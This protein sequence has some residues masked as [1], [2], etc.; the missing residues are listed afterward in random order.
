MA[1]K[2]N[3]ATQ[4]A[5]I[6][7]DQVA[8]AAKVSPA[9]VSRVLNGTAKVS[10]DKEKAVRKAVAKY[11]FTPNATARRLAGGRSGLIA[12]LMEESSEE[13]FL[14]PFW[15]Q[16]VQGF[17]TAITEAGLHPMLLIRPKSGTEDS[18]FSTLQ[19]GQMDGLAIF[20]WH[21]PLRSFE[22]MLDPKMAVVF[23]GDLGGSKKYPY[24]DVDNVKGGYLATKHLIDSECKNIVTITG[25]LKLQ[26]GRDRLDGYEKALTSAGI[27]IN[28]QLIIHG[29]YTQSKAEEL[30]RQF[31]KRKIKFDGVFAGNDLSALGAI[32]VLLQNGI[33]VPGKVKVVGF[34][35]SPIASRN[36]PSITTIR[37]PI[38]ELGA[39]VAHS[40][41][42]ILDGEEVE[43]KV[44]DVRLIKRQSSGAK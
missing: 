24:V 27:K 10:A 15:G 16:V 1:K 14:N 40:L 28:D 38:R 9:T 18:L 31:L 30:I 21:R 6:T 39:Q 34:D 12:L 33:T 25:D 43:D 3:V 22:K 35:D 29:D 37:Q 41:L 17:S 7:I 11:N 26:S 4:Q 19:A 42:A 23:G 2:L 5:E 44:L 36:K 13:F 32:N 20:S 8:R